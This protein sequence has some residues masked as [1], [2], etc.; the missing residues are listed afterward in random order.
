ML[1]LRVIVTASLSRT[2]VGDY[3]NDGPPIDVISPGG[4][5]AM[6]AR[7]LVMDSVSFWT[8]CNSIV[9]IRRSIILESGSF[10]IIMGKNQGETHKLM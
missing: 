4:L 5:L 6:K 7:I 2:L 1:T 8:G 9:L 10:E 3:S